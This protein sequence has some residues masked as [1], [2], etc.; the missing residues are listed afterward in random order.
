MK[1]ICIYL[2][3][4]IEVNQERHGIEIYYLLSIELTQNLKSSTNIVIMVFE[5]AVYIQIIITIKLNLNGLFETEML[6]KLI[7]ILTV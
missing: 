5:N 7:F 4:I 3:L 2:N 6:L 1:S